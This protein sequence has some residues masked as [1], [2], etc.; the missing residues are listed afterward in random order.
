MIRAFI[1]SGTVA[2]LFAMWMD[3]PKPVKISAVVIP[4][5]KI[6][7]KAG[8]HDQF[9]QWRTGWATGYGPC[10]LQDKYFEI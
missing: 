6:T 7:Y 3:Q 8:G 5:C 2:A 1:F 9:G 4:Y 10:S